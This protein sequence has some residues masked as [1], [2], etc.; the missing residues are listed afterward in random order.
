M[1]RIKQIIPAALAGALALSSGAMG[2]NV[3]VVDE[4]IK[5]TGQKQKGKKEAQEAFLA[6]LV[7]AGAGGGLEEKKADELWNK[8][9]KAAQDWVTA[10]ADAA[11]KAETYKDIKEPDAGDKTEPAKSTRPGAGGK[12]DA[13]AE[14]PAKP[15]K[16]PKETGPSVAEETRKALCKKPAATKE[17]VLATVKGVISTAKEERVS[18][19]YDATKAVLLILRE[20]KK[21]EFKLP[22]EGK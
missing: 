7:L 11:G 22:G 15:A 4:I 5:V 18:Q 1:K 2:A 16:E 14:K 13:K 6:R 3:G 12:T 20:Q 9:S 19:I 8:L 17:E 21:L 10:N